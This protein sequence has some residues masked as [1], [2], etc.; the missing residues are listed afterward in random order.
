MFGVVVNLFYRPTLDCL[1]G[2]HNKYPVTQTRNNTQVVGDQDNRGV[3]L[4]PQGIHQVGN[5]RLYR[6]IQGRCRFVSNE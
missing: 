3:G 1:T 5:L 2:I 6:D 4:F